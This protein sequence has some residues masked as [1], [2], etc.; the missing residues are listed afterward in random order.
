MRRDSATPSWYVGWSKGRPERN[1]RARFGQDRWALPPRSRSRQTANG[2]RVDR[3]V[4]IDPRLELPKFESRV[5]EEED[6]EWQPGADGLWAE[7]LQEKE[8]GG[9][10][11]PGVF[12]GP[13][14]GEG[15]RGEDWCV[16]DTEKQQVQPFHCSLAGVVSSSDAWASSFNRVREIGEIDRNGD[17]GWPGSLSSATD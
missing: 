3:S 1:R 7:E 4:R 9:E 8:G 15:E 2:K 16:Q 14:Q 12:A 10:C 17:D 5:D 11:S 6:D 13:G